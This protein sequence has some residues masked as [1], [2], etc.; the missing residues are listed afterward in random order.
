MQFYGGKLKTIRKRERW[1]T[2]A[3]SEKCGVT[4][5]TLTLWEKGKVIPSEEKVRL[6]ASSLNIKVNEISDMDTNQNISGRDLSGITGTLISMAKAD[7]SDTTKQRDKHIREIQNIY[8]EQEQIALIVKAFLNSMQSILYVKDTKLR[9]I[10]V[11]DAFQKTF[12]LEG[13]TIIGKTDRNILPAHDAK[14][15][16]AEDQMVLSTGKA[17]VNK[18]AFIVGTR[19]RKWGLISKYPIFEK[20]KVIGVM[21]NIIDTS[22]QKEMEFIQQ[23]INS[24]MHKMDASLAILD[25]SSN[26]LL[27]AAGKG[28]EIFGNEQ[29]VKLD[30]LLNTW[31]TTIVHPEDFRNRCALVA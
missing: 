27:Y 26:K 9:Y 12:S 28:S 30:D 19:K 17:V 18:E 23:L 11:N 13:Y 7:L 20:G 8:R 1:T 5:Q 25:L 31:L 16:T 3:L 2:I 15:N 14:L 29:S 10:I 24:T 4:R 21:G 22:K 6:I